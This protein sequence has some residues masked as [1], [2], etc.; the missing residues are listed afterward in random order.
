MT[1][2]RVWT[3]D[4]LLLRN[5]FNVKGYGF[6]LQEASRGE[7]SGPLADDLRQTGGGLWI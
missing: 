6:S 7:Q 4:T 2:L 3:P 1:E 5:A